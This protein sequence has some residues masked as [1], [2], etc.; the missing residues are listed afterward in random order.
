MKERFSQ[1]NQVSDVFGFLYNIPDLKNKTTSEVKSMC[2]NLEKSLS[3]KTAEG[4]N[5][6]DI[7]ATGLCSELRA[8]SHHI[9]DS[10]SSPES[11]LNYIYKHNLENGFPN[12]CVALRILLTL[13]LSVAS[14]E[15]SF[16]KL[17]LIKT[18]LRSTMSQE[19]LVGLAT[20]SIESDIAR[21]LDSK[22]L[23][24]EFAKQ[25]ARKVPLGL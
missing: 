5:E 13:P 25:K 11:V 18:Y 23:I 19:R 6:S 22:A 12:L 17:K 8:I 7:A 10:V 3:I 1:L 9:K 15:R 14:A 24:K 16:S 4:L 2:Q 21:Q 20:I